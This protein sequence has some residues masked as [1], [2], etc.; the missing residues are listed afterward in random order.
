MKTEYTIVE[1]ENTFK[2]RWEN[3][4]RIGII[5]KNFKTKAD[6]EKYIESIK[7]YFQV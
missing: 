5:E 3:E 6:A 2:I 1:V 7:N 4:K